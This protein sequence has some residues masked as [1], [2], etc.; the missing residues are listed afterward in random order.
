MQD[1][2]RFLLWRGPLAWCVDCFLLSGHTLSFACSWME[3]GSMGAH[4]PVLSKKN[5]N[6]A[7]RLPHY[8][9]LRF[10]PLPPASKDDHFKYGCPVRASRN[11]NY[12]YRGSSFKYW[13]SLAFPVC[14]SEQ[15]TCFG[16]VHPSGVL[17]GNGSELVKNNAFVSCAG[18]LNF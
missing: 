11:G 7:K 5:N 12:K 9:D 6:P 2:G 3:G 16:G 13:G 14:E 18:V 1:S 15:G 17:L 4:F 10:P 8:Y